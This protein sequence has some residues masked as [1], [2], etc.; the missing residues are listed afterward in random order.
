[1][2]DCVKEALSLVNLELKQLSSQGTYRK[3]SFRFGIS[4][5]RGAALYV[6]GFSF[7]TGLFSDTL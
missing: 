6:D 5:I 1:L 7:E 2:A 3:N 4:M